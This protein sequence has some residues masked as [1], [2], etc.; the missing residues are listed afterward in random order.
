MKTINWTTDDRVA[1]NDWL[2]TGLGLKFLR[3]LSEQRPEM[4][5]LSISD[6]TKIA[7]AGAVAKGYEH[8]L[9]EIDQMRQ[10]P[11][12]PMPSVQYVEVEKD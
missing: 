1:L 7:L 2:F 12:V 3:Y 9:A 11:T 10:V 6:I 5:D 4:P 8:A